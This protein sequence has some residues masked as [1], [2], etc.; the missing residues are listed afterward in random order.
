MGDR[1]AD[2]PHSPPLGMII[3]VL[4][5]ISKLSV[6]ATVRAIAPWL[7]PLFVALIAITFIPQLTLWLPKAAGMIR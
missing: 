6:E 5:R 7:V 4:S 3:F 1:R 2:H